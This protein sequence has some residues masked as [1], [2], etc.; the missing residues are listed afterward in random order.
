MATGAKRSGGRQ[1]DARSSLIPPGVSYLA[2]TIRPPLWRP[3]DNNYA[4]A[5]T[6]RFEIATCICSATA[7]ATGGGNALPI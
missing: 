5:N 4:T 7:R 3:I 6:L 2:E 1:R